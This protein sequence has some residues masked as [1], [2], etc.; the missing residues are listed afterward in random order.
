MPL[1]DESFNRE[2]ATFP[3]SFFGGYGSTCVKK[4]SIEEYYS[5]IKKN[6][7]L[8]FA[9]TWMELESIML[10]QISQ[11]KQIPLHSLWNLRNKNKQAK[12][13]NER[14]RERRERRE[15]ERERER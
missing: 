1:L 14:K 10:S 7:I 6:E 9:M 13:K 4:A 15:R 12:G 8:P 2:F 11:R 3:I 5:A